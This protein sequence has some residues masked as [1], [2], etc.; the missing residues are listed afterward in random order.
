M[1]EHPP[2]NYSYIPPDVLLP[3]TKWVDNHKGIFSVNLEAVSSVHTQVSF[4]VWH[5]MLERRKRGM[6]HGH[7]HMLFPLS[8]INCSGNCYHI[9]RSLFLEMFRF[10]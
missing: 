1:I 10:L 2:A 8:C 7:A 4:S 3:G 6:F 5:V 9:R